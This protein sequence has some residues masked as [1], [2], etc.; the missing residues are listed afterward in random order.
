MVFVIQDMDSRLCIFCDRGVADLKTLL[1]LPHT[2][3][4]STCERIMRS[5]EASGLSYIQALLFM[6]ANWQVTFLAWNCTKSTY[7]L[8]ESCMMKQVVEEF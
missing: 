4:T 1:L 2:G 6:M 8:I 7:I 3:N 5:E